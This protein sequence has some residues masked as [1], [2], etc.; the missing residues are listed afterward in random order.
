MITIMNIVILYLNL[1]DTSTTNINSYSY[2]KVYTYSQKNN[3]SIKGFL[4]ETDYRIL[5]SY[6]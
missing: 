3:H 1:G 5:W 2:R 6:I 4:F